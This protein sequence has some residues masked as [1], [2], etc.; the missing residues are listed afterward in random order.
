MSKVAFRSVV[1]SHRSLHKVLLEADLNAQMQYVPVPEYVKGMR[2]TE[3][4]EAL[5]AIP[6]LQIGVR[7]LRIESSFHRLQMDHHQQLRINLRRQRW[8]LLS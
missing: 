4:T 1:L 5:A 6:S 2:Q 7:L 8:E 3:R